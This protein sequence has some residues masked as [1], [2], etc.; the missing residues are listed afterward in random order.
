MI[1]NN[2]LRIGQEAVSNALKHAQARVIELEV[3][4]EPSRV[5]L[6]V[7]DDGRGFDPAAA[8]ADGR[9]G[10]R[11]MQERVEQMH[12]ELTIRRGEKGGTC[13]EVAV[14]VLDS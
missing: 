1:E 6:V 7:R 2:L 4:F 11:G 10:L 12:G 3:S 14:D 8:R 13:V 5:R 9:F